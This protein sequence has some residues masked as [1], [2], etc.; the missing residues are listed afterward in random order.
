MNNS[1]HISLDTLAE[2][3]EG[4]VAS[5]T[6]ETSLVHVSTCSACQDALRRLQQLILMMK[7]DQAE[8]VPQ[9]FAAL[10]IK[11]FQAEN[12]PPSRQMV[13]TLTFDSRSAIPAFGMRSL[14]SPSRQLL[15]SGEEADLDLRVTVQNDEYLISGQVLRDGCVCGLVELS[16]ADG[17]TEANLNTLCE[18]TFPG[19]PLGSYSLRVKMPDLEIVIPE[20]ELRVED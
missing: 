19:M 4:S 2:I 10:A 20:L 7:S 9:D 3:A 18:F 16:C 1:Q 8:A 6:Q 11:I 17:T 13:G 15:Y 14:H 5:E 12:H